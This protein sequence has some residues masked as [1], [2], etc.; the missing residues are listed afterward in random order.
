MTADPH[1]DISDARGLAHEFAN[2]MQVVNGNLELLD[3]RTTDERAR[4]YIENARTAAERLAELSRKLSAPQRE[5][6]RRKR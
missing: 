3:L 1:G 4:R 2:L 5:V 6:R